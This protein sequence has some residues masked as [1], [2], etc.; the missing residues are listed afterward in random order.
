MVKKNEILKQYVFLDASGKPSELLK[1]DN[2]KLDL[3]INSFEELQ[4]IKQ[5]DLKHLK[6]LPIYN[7]V[8]M[9]YWDFFRCHVEEDK[10]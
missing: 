7:F 10:E 1:L 9:L 2:F 3:G 8:V 5:K 4:T 6:T